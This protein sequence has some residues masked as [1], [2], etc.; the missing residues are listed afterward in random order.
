[1]IDPDRTLELLN[2][3]AFTIAEARDVIDE[4]R[5]KVRAAIGGMR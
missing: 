5:C 3:P 2:P 4:P 1:M